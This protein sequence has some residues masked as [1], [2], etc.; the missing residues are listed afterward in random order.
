[1][2][3]FRRSSLSRSPFIFLSFIRADQ[4]TQQ[5]ARAIINNKPEIEFEVASINLNG[6]LTRCLWNNSIHFIKY[7][8]YISYA[9]V[10]IDLGVEAHQNAQFTQCNRFQR[11]EN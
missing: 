6:N 5:D 2:E 9:M 10:Q 4:H 8:R 3:F 1:M 7:K 11:S